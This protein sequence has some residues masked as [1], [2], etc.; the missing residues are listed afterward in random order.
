VD[1]FM[2]DWHLTHLGTF[3]RGGAGLVVFEASGVQDVGR[4]T[5]WDAGVW[6]DEHIAP[7]KRIVD[8]LH[9]QQALAGLQLAHAGRKA[10]TYPPHLTFPQ[11][12]ATVPVEQGGW[13]PVGPSAVRC[14][15]PDV[16][17]IFFNG[18]MLT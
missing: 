16:E 4:I 12:G 3:A 7:L 5:P 1:G 2:N 17:H 10:S 13:V 18:S 11:P 8:F 15:P 9:S 6:K 14:D